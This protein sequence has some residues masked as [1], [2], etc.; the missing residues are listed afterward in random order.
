MLPVIYRR[1]ADSDFV[2]SVG[3]IKMLASV[4][5]VT[6]EFLDAVLKEAQPTLHVCK[7]PG[8]Y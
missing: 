5:L 7:V 8:K 2:L 4:E 6:R 3:R 1:I